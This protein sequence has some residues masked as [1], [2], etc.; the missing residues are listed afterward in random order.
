[1]T[2]LI[3]PMMIPLLTFYLYVLANF[4]RELRRAMWNRIPG[5]KRR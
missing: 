5:A 3:L 2:I 1:M 4:Q